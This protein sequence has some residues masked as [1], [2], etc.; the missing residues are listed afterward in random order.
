MEVIIEKG[1]LSG[2]VGAIPSK[3]DAHRA[4]IAAALC[5]APST[6]ALSMLSED[7]EATLG[8]LKAMG[9]SAAHKDGMWTITPIDH[10]KKPNAPLLNCR[11][12]GSTLRFLLPVAAVFCNEA[13]FCGEGRLPE[14]PLSPLFRAMHAHG[15]EADK[16]SLPLSLRGKLLPGEFHIAG[17]V[18]SQFVSG[19]LF[20]LPSLG[21]DSFIHIEGALESAS[22]VDMTIRTL[23]RFG[24][25]VEKRGDGFFIAGEQRFLAQKR[26]E[27]EGDWSSAAFFIGANALGGKIKLTGL[28]EESAQPDKALGPLLPCLGGEIDVSPCPD[29]FPILAV[30]AAFFGGVTR[31]TGGARLRMKES[32]RIS[33]MAQCLSAMGAS[34]KEYPDGMEVLGSKALHGAKIDAHND[35]R[36]AM[37]MSIAGAYTGKMHIHGAQCVKKSYPH[38]YEDFRSLGGKAYVL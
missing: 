19:L 22:Y 34:C 6:L 20:A 36:V 24:V 33:A 38:F 10:E 23:A 17:N 26:Y 2:T 15:V 18:S 8:C 3:S 16:P 27:V 4:L 35:H 21:G 25:R 13:R 5:D 7:T 12:S 30:C 37:A 11:E 31:F 29:L 1:A 14:R 9:A 32:D 28:N